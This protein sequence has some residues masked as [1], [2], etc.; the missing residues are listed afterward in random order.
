M[1]YISEF[2]ADRPQ[3]SLV[4][5][6][7]AGYVRLIDYMGDDMSIVRAARV[8]YDADQRT[9]EDHDKDEKLI[10][11]MMSHRH[12]TPFEAVTLTFEFKMPIFVARQLVR[13]RTQSINEVSAR[14]TELPEEFYFPDQKNVTTQDPKNKQARTQEPNKNAQE[15]ICALHDHCGR[16][17]MMYK[18]ALADGIPRELARCFL[19][20]NVYTR[21]FTTMNLHNAF[22]M[23]NLRADK[24]AQ[25]E[26]QQYA[27][28]MLRLMEYVAPT[29][30][31]AFRRF[32]DRSDE[33]DLK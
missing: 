24:H 5:V 6:L 22:H 32:T 33:G 11:Y 25:W 30:V 12:T 19:P 14:Y 16:S 1:S 18:D 9:G 15:F 10:R 23:V 29:A 20:L 27:I 8:S 21:W 7:N 3:I 4:H 13:H 28:A 26:T 2:L 17:M 31:D